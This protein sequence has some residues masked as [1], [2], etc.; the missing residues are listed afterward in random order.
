MNLHENG[1]FVTK[2]VAVGTL[3]EVCFVITVLLYFTQ[4][5]LLVDKLNVRRYTA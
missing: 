3:H 5:N 1:T 2:Y 4:Y